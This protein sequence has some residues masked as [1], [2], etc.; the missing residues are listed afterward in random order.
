MSS[1]VKRTKWA[2]WERRANAGLLAGMTALSKQTMI[3]D[4]A[5]ERGHSDIKELLK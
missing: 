3:A 1:P 5:V 2:R 4:L